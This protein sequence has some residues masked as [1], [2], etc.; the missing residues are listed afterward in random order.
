MRRR[1]A[2]GSFELEPVICFG[3]TLGFGL[4]GSGLGRCWTMAPL[5]ILSQLYRR[6]VGRE[7][8]M[9]KRAYS[10]GFGWDLLDSY[11]AILAGLEETYATYQLP[12]DQG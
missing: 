3:V 10:L 6:K 5:A 7:E 11:D 12:F 4:P 9:T 8:K 2:S 1:L